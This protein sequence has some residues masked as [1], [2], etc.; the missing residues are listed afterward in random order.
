MCFFLS[1]RKESGRGTVPDPLAET[2]PRYPSSARRS[3]SRDGRDRAWQDVCGRRDQPGFC[4]ENI[5]EMI[6]FR[7]SFDFLKKWSIV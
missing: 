4:A 3:I 6:F 2:A 5:E 7:F 1:N